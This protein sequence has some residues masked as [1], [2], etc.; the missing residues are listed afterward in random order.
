MFGSGGEKLVLTEVEGGF[1]MP[2]GTM[3]FAEESEDQKVLNKMQAMANFATYFYAEKGHNYPK[4]KED[5]V[6][7]SNHF[8]WENPLTDKVNVPVVE[9]KRVSGD[10]FDET[11]TET[12]RQMRDMKGLFPADDAAKPQIGLI[13][14]ISLLPDD[15]N[16]ADMVG[17]GFLIRAYGKDGKLIKSSDPGKAFVIAQ[18]ARSSGRC[19]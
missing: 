5:A 9:V 11:F 15:P 14:C 16:A 13:E 1:V 7:G 4:G 19:I 2:D 10:N 8:G 3:L 6:F 18:K 17:T 12:L